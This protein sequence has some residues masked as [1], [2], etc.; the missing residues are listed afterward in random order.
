MFNTKMTISEKFDVVASLLTEYGVDADVLEFIED[1]KAKS[2][3][4]GSGKPTATQVANE[5]IK[6]TILATLSATPMTISD[7][8]KSNEALAEFSTSKMS[9]LLKQLVDKKIV[10]KTYEKKKAYFSLA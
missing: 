6:D 10:T 5:G 7:I 9:A 3:R 1:R 4:K 8:Q 2:V